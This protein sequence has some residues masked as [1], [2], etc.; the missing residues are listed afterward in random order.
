MTTVHA[1]DLSKEGLIEMLQYWIDAREPDDGR[2]VTVTQVIGPATTDADAGI[3]ARALVKLACGLSAGWLPLREQ[4]LADAA[5][6]WLSVSEVPTS[7]YPVARVET[8]PA[9]SA[10]L[11]AARICFGQGGE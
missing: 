3:R 2:R 10:A 1:I 6:A 4:D 7:W 5:T 8:W 11:V 9:T